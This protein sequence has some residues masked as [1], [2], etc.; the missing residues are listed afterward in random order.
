M[1][2]KATVASGETAVFTIVVKVERRQRQT[3]RQSPTRLLLPVRHR[4]V[5]AGNNTGTATTTVFGQA[6]LSV[7][8]TD[9]PD[10]VCVNGNITYTIN[11]TNNGPGPGSNTTVTDAVPPTRHSYRP[12]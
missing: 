9:S 3:T 8:K 6:D 12:R 11:F 7:T 10:P 2:T 4:T 1:F 5:I